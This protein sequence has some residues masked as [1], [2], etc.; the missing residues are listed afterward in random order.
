MVVSFIIMSLF[1]FF[2]VILS[3]RWGGFFILFVWI[4]RYC[5]FNDLMIEV[6]RENKDLW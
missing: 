1:G 6:E 3:G 4:L 5:K 2:V